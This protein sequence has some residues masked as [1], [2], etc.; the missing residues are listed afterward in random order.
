MKILLLI[1]F[2][3]VVFTA[4][5]PFPQ[6]GATPTPAVTAQPTPIIQPTPSAQPTLPSQEVTL[7]MQKANTIV[8]SPFEIKGYAPG[9]WFFEGQLLGEIKTASNE[10][11]ATFP[12]QAQGGWMTTDPVLFTGKAA[13]MV[14]NA[15]ASI[16]L[17]IKNDNPSGL[18]ENE[19]SA[20]FPLKIAR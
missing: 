16:Y 3:A 7:E 20:A 1:V 5:A 14:E 9:S 10:T 15:D 17:I 11:L 4:C 18:P 8:T 6:P 19:K 12:L 13:F 2:A